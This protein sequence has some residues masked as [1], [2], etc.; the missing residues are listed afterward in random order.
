MSTGLESA[1]N[2]LLNLK[3]FPATIE[4]PTQAL[5][6]FPINI[7]PGNYF[8]H[9]QGPEETVISGHEFVLSAEELRGSTLPMPPKIGDIIEAPELGLMSVS[10]VIPLY[11]LGG[12]ILGYRIR[13]S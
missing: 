9:L 2:L 1:F 13:T 11:A 3:K 10:E 5:G 8:R 12:N 7:S 4:R 6:P